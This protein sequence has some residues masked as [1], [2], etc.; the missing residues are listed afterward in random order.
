MGDL[1]NENCW[2]HRWFGFWC[3]EGSQ[4]VE[5]P[6]L[7]DW[8][9]ESWLNDEKV[10]YATSYLCSA[11]VVVADGLERC[12]LCGQVSSG[13]IAYRTDGE[14]YWSDSLTHYVV[15]HGICLPDALYSRIETANGVPPE[16]LWIARAEY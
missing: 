11:P 4:F 8:T 13:S 10:H 14:W 3:E 6:R 7:R 2:P 5:C 9:H 15:E 16:Q 1:L 12:L